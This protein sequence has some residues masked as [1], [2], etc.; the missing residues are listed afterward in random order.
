MYKLFSCLLL[1]LLTAPAIAQNPHDGYIFWLPSGELKI[2]DAASEKEFNYSATATSHSFTVKPRS[3]RMGIP[4]GQ[5]VI[6]RDS[7]TIVGALYAFDAFNPLLTVDGKSAG[8]LCQVTFLPRS[9]TDGKNEMKLEFKPPAGQVVSGYLVYYTDDAAKLGFPVDANFNQRVDPQSDQGGF[10]EYRNGVLAFWQGG[11]KD[12]KR[13]FLEGADKATTPDAQRLFR[14]LAR[15]ADAEMQFKKIKSGPGFYKMG[16]YSMTNGFWDLA[17]DCFK[18]ATEKMPSNPD[19]WY[20]LGDA[21]SYKLSDLDVRMEKIVPYYK[22]A[23]ELYPRTNSNTYRNHVGLFKKLRVSD[24]EVLTMSQ[25]Q[26][27]YVRKNWDWCST[28]ME[29]AS[30]GALRMVN[31]Y[32]VYEEEFD[33]TKG[34][35]PRTFAALRFRPGDTETFMKFTG[36]GASGA[37]GHDCGPYLSSPIE[38]GLRE[39]DVM[40]H[41]WN[42]TLDWAVITGELGIGVPATHSSDWC[43]FEPISSMGMGHKSCNRY[44]MTPGMYRYVRGSDPITTPQ[45]TDWLVSGPS[46]L[47]PEPK[48]LNNDFYTESRKRTTAVQPPAA[49]SL[50]IKPRV[51][52]GYIDFN[53]TFPDAPKNAYAFARTYIYSPT[54][55][56]V[57]MWLGADDN[58]RVWLNGRLV[59]KGLYWACVLFQ[60]A[61]EQEQVSGALVL[62]KGWNSLLVQ[63]T[64]VQFDPKLMIPEPRPDAWGFAIRLCDTQNR[65]VPGLKYQSV[66]PLIEY[67]PEGGPVPVLGHRIDPRSPKT[68]SWEKVAD[69]YTVLLPELTIDDLR[70]ITGYKTLAANDDIFFDL[71]GEQI[72]PAFRSLVI[73]KSDPKNVALN[74][75]LNWYFSPNEMAAVVRYKRGPQV[76]DLLFLRPEG[77]ETYLALLPVKP[78]AKKLGIKRHADQVIGY[79][80]T[81]RDDCPNGRIVLVVDTYLGDKLPVDEE[82]LLQIRKLR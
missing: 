19:A 3:T 31:D 73:E 30:R 52:G 79:F 61:K 63:V 51:D 62:E 32:Q 39:W 28:I 18:K 64:N 41:E 43:G 81:R 45:I 6:V 72:D 68:Y 10:K 26:M 78:E 24:K 67:G 69:D 55:E 27:D 80:L 50:T 46:E 40:Y 37:S 1:A 9:L 17:A 58:I 57:R 22:K 8:N 56:K 12:A 49:D 23:A 35:D 36:W 60:D 66:V 54:K 71:S 48:E 13:I 47:M 4:S 75:E 21:M 11:H 44:Y 77:Y 82:D 14:R 16:L 33:N 59:H 5:I 38:I 70:T 76:R 34:D 2:G 42:H 25:E 15:W 74:N 65:E 53:V 29:A 7:T 20:M